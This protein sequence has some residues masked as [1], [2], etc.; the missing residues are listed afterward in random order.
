VTVLCGSAQ[1][2]RDRLEATIA[3]GSSGIISVGIA[4]GLSPQLA[5]GD[6]VVASGI[7]SANERYA[8]DQRW[9]NRLREALTG[10]VFADIAGVD[11]PI[12]DKA[13]KRAMYEDLNTVAVDMESHVAARVAA[14]H[15]VPFAACRV[16]I[17]PAD[18]TLPPAALVGMRDDGRT[19][20][21]AVLQSVARMPWQ[22]PALLRVVADA[23]IARTALSRGRQRLG[24]DLSFPGLDE[25]QLQFS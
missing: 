3:A 5:P 10:A 15:G 23:W 14:A 17:D 4:G 21:L 18:R 8:T 1:R 9:S 6:W 16:I 20:L 11:E 13:T 2:Y 22:V 7:V 25:R 24:A 19:D 12:V